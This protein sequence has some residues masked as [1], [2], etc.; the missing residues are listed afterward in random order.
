MASPPRVVVFGSSVAE[1]SYH[2]RSWAKQLTKALGERGI[3]VNLSQSGS[4]TR[5][6]LSRVDVVLKERPDVVIVSLSLPNEGLNLRSFQQGMEEIVKRLRPS[7]ARVVLCGPYPFN[8]CENPQIRQLFLDLIAWYRATFPDLAFVDFFSGIHDGRGCWPK[9]T[10]EDAV[11]PN[12][13]GFDLMFS[14]IDLRLILGDKP[15]S[16]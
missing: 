10:F 7:G 3:V 2:E 1:G 14:C 12:D 16:M 11:H 5:T 6:A 4:D 13:R 9:G 15:V 8:G